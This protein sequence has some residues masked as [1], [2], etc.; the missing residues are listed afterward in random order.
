MNASPIPRA[1]VG[2][3][4]LAVVPEFNSNKDGWNKRLNLFSGRSLSD[5][6]LQ[7]EQ[8]NR[9]GHLAL[10]G[11]LRSAGVVCG[12]QVTKAPS[13]LFA[14]V[15]S[16]PLAEAASA[17]VTEAA[18]DQVKK[19]PAMDNKL[20]IQ[21]AAGQGLCASGEDVWVPRS[22]TVSL[23]GLPVFFNQDQFT[24]LGAFFAGGGVPTLRTFILV[25]QP[26]VLLDTGSADP[27]RCTDWDD[28]S[29]AFENER[30]TDGVRLAL[31]AWDSGLEAEVNKSRWRNQLANEIFYQEL[32]G[33]PN[34]RPSPD[35][36]DPLAWKR[37]GLPI[38]LIALTADRQEIEFIDGFAVVRTGGRPRPKTPVVPNSGDPLIWQARLQQFAEQLVEM[39]PQGN[40]P[41]AQQDWVQ[42]KVAPCFRFLPPVGLL[43]AAALDP[44]AP[45]E[46][47]NFFFPAN[48]QWQVAPIPLEQL[49]LVL[50][51]SA[52]LAP[53]DLDQADQ[54]Q[55][56]VPVPQAWF[57]PNLLQVEQVNQL[58]QQ[59]IDEFQGRRAQWLERRD[60][61]RQRAVAIALC[62]GGQALGFPDPDPNQLEQPEEGTA[63]SLDP[64]ELDYQTELRD[65]VP[66]VLPIQTLRKSLLSQT[67]ID[68]DAVTVSNWSATILIPEPLSKKVSYNP[69][70]RL[71]T[72]KGILSDDERDLLIKLSPNDRTAIEDLCNRSKDNT[73]LNILEQKGLQEFINFLESKVAQAD[74]A[75]EFG[76]LQ[77]R[78]SMYRVRQQVLGLEDA[79]R[80]A[81]SS[82]L[83]D[84]ATRESAYA[85]QKD[86]SAYFQAAKERQV[87][88][89]A[90]AP[91]SVAGA[92]A[93]APVEGATFQLRD[94]TVGLQ[95]M[96][97]ASTGFAVGAT[98]NAMARF[99]IGTV[100]NT[101]SQL[102]SEIG[103]GIRA[104]LLAQPLGVGS[105]S[106]ASDTLK[107]SLLFESSFKN[108][109]VIEQ[110]SVIGR[111]PDSVIVGERLKQPAAVETRDFSLVGRKNVVEN[112]ALLGIFKDLPVPG[113]NIN[114]GQVKPGAF[115]IEEEALPTNADEVEYFSRAVR[116][117]DRTVAAL[118]L[119]EGRVQAYRGAIALCRKTMADLLALQSQ[120]NQRLRVVET[121]LAESRQDVSVAKALLAEET[122]RVGRINERR[123]RILSEHVTFLAYQR[124]RSA[125]LLL[126]PP[127]RRLDPGYVSDPLPPCLN[128]SQ[129]IPRELRAMT[130]L[131]RDAPLGWFSTLPQS[132]DR[133][134]RVDSLVR[135]FESARQASNPGFGSAAVAVSITTGSTPISQSIERIYGQRQQLVLQKRQLIN[136][137]DIN[138]I[139]ALSWQ[140]S[141]KKAE[142][143]LTLGTLLDGNHR[144]PEVSNQAATLLK[145]LSQVATCLHARFAAVRPALR[146][147]WAERLSQFD[148]PVNLRTL[149]NLPRW[150]EI[151]DLDRRELQSLVDWLF[152]QFSSSQPEAL[153]F[154]SDLVRLSLLLACHA[155][156]NQIISG[157]VLKPTTVR[158]D[159]RVQISMD[160]L[161]VR[162]GMPVLMYSTLNTVVA[163]GIVEDLNGGLAIAKIT[164]TT[165]VN[166]ALS[167]ATRVQFLRQS[168]F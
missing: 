71:I 117:L 151:D 53:F 30:R 83:A 1:I 84:I 74:D 132:L 161:Q 105:Q 69:Q 21:I 147:D 134:D 62:L 122:A 42:N 119:G 44:R 19:V 112:L 59:R 123:Q 68:N 48:Y 3:Q 91:R 126:T 102:S 46:S 160:P 130:D 86:L 52:S 142:Q 80:L 155:P 31:C 158:P 76:F 28:S 38:A 116:A 139:A 78:T 25:L 5:L 166:L 37:Q 110:S 33:E 148:E 154:G 125:D 99:D 73:D 7:A 100:S 67:P 159:G 137:V 29:R 77:S 16:E 15:P 18:S 56:W 135:L 124:P 58:F 136:Q 146:L 61:L 54:V 101:P 97:A 87:T 168:P 13:E 111:I 23:G 98:T 63:P 156:V 49:E 85:T 12:L 50:K 144:R 94:R 165:Q 26:T 107:T 14:E 4:V 167:E 93:A 41:A 10:L 9:S 115:P 95:N 150:G 163:R 140:E 27:N 40:T 22:L 106:S 109:D 92:K 96:R 149:T 6:A 66:V 157:R 88:S 20:G 128:D 120:I 55:V 153:E 2:E 60:W 162:I 81:T 32:R 145:Q 164:Q 141:R 65:G 89:P 24:S 79:S 114:F 47:Q 138:A 104:E 72:V 64:P 17:Q 127:W 70:S 103:T 90:P 121:E 133:I 35:Q 75:V 8:N 34:N 45:R 11:Q 118:R 39:E 131:L 113:S 57:E 152:Q 36:A 129:P 143:I 82:T 43:P 108:I 51:D